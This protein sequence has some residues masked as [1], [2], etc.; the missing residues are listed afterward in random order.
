M[1]IKLQ[2]RSSEIGTQRGG[3]MQV[4]VIMP[5]YNGA[6]YIKQAIDSVLMQEVDVE[7]L[8]VDDQSTDNLPEVMAEYEN[9]ERVRWIQNE[10]N[11]GVAKSRNHGVT[12]AKG[13]YIAFLDADD[14]WAPGKLKAQLSMME[15]EGAVLSGTARELMSPAGESTGR[16]IPVKERITLKELLTHNSISCSS[17][18]VKRDVMLKYPMTHDDSH[19]DY[20]TWIQILKEHDWALGIDEPY[21]KYRLSEGSKSRNKF[22]SAWMTYKVYRYSGYGVFA[23]LRH[24]ITYAYNGFKKYYM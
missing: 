20:I 11:L 16:M 12:L 15:A 18:V 4:S 8:V 17:V 7:V 3:Y 6:R 2:H 23:S 1:Q 21:L 13:E 9:D 24:W 14:W 22:K 10:V 19:E 5:V